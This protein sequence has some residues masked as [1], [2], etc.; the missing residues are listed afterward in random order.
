MAARAGLNAVT[1]YLHV[2]EERLAE[3]ARHGGIPDEG[4]QIRRARHRNRSQVTRQV[5]QVAA[6]RRIGHAGD[7]GIRW[8]LSQN[9]H[10][11]S[12]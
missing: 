11:W 8:R 2:P 3:G 5:G 12:N 4:V 7:G 10:S 9:D 1:S 6:Q